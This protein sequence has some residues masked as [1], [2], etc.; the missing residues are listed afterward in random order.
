MD[1]GV[2]I[3]LAHPFGR[4]IDVFQGGDDPVGGDD[5]QPGSEQSEQDSQE[6]QPA[7]GG[8]P[9]LIDFTVRRHNPQVH[10][11]FQGDEGHFFFDSP[12]VMR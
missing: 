10:T 3:S 9:F 1:E 11:V 12:V 2:I 8:F 4:R 7:V 5:G 6:Q